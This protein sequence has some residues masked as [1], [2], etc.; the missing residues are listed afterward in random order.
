[1]QVYKCFFRILGKQKGQIILYLSIFLTVSMLV[2][3]QGSDSKEIKFEASS[4]NFAV[5]Y[6]DRSEVSE[7]LAKYLSR[8]NERK[9]I[10]DERETVQDELYNRNIVC[11]VRIP[12]GFAEAVQEG[13]EVNMPE[14]VSVPGTVYGEVFEQ[15]VNGY[16]RI[17]CSYL[18]GGF[19]EGEAVEK[20]GSALAEQ[21]EVKL[22]DSRNDGT[23]SKMYY[24]FQTLPYIYI[25]ICI[26]AIGPILIIFN[27]KDV[28]D[29]IHSSS[30]PMNR[31]NLELYAGMV[32]TAF[33][34]LAIH[35]VM[36]ILCRVDV[37]SL[38][39]L[40]FVIN[41]SC[42]LIVSL[43]ITFLI[44]QI[45]KSYTVL[46]MISNIV[47]LGLSFLGGVFV[48]LELMGDG[49]VKVAH[50]L[51]SYWYIRACGWIDTF[52]SGDS[53]VPL[54]G[55]M[56]MQLLFG[57]AFISAGLAWAKRKKS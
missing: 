4:Y 43:G 6:R 15:K 13:G 24:Y 38:K 50:F 49:M 25:A 34:L 30:Y 21:V 39:G 3:I 44:G 2:S 10:E 37:F 20:T 35:L 54:A 57:A 31:I 29:R 17:L 40:L 27:K 42:F 12:E 56:G 26:V 36:V 53:F 45:A 11:A 46:S 19:S 7:G 23:R 5:F 33:S 52:L 41:E 1:M 22:A 8:D 47:G 18:A 16:I 32:V 51:P 9:E 28:R 14:I 48:P 55:F